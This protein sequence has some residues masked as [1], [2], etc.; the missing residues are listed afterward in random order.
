MNSYTMKKKT[1]TETD[2]LP[3]ALEELKRTTG[4][5]GTFQPGFHGRDATGVAGVVVSTQG[6]SFFVCF[7][8]AG[9]V[10]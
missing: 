1:F 3:T 4:I 9:R 7:G 10:A 6:T 2:L 5:A 8:R